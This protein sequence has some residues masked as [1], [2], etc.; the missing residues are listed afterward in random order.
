MCPRSHS[1]RPRLRVASHCLP[2]QF[3]CLGAVPVLLWLCLP[4]SAEDR[5]K[6][7]IANVRAWEE[8]YRDIEVVWRY[9]Y[10]SHDAASLPDFLAARAQG[11]RRSITQGPLLY[12]RD[13]QSMTL[14]SGALLETTG[15]H[16]YDG[17]VARSVIGK[18]AQLYHWRA[19]ASEQFRA[20]T[21]LV[22]IWGFI[23]FPLSLYLTGGSELQN[24]P[25]GSYKDN[26]LVTSFEKEEVVD[27]L[28]CFKVRCDSLDNKSPRTLFARRYLWLVPSRNYL[29]IKMEG[30][31]RHWTMELPLGVVQARDWREIEPDLWLPFE[32]VS[33]AYD[34]EKA[35]RDK[36]LVTWN[37]THYF[38]E[39]VDLHPNYDISL[40]RDI[41]FPDGTLVYEIGEDLE[42]VKGYVQGETEEARPFL[43][44][45]LRGWLLVVLANAALLLA[46]L[47]V[48]RW[49]RAHRLPSVA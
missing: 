21:F 13:D 6:Q 40:F 38:V 1:S 33:V 30:Y 12:F 36:Q 34:P 45:G 46:A 16:A 7:I 32:I 22:G 29:P 41:P 9:E 18:S 39:H 26:Y 25:S 10:R 35:K 28:R 3:G 17:E 44:L 14:V 11:R 19:E 48:W 2:I 4:V 23:H 43:G 15:L 42:I 49:Q 24:H 5:L 27:G 37:T 8:V 20:H 47:L 31:V